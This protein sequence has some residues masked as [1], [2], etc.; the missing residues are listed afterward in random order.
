MIS[1]SEMSIQIENARQSGY[2]PIYKRAAQQFGFTV[3]TLLA[4]DSRESCLGLCLD[5][6]FKGDNGNAWGLS[7]ID[8]RFHPSF[9]S[10]HDPTDHEAVVLYGASLLRSDTNA[11]GMLRG[12]LV[13][14]NAGRDAVIDAQAQGLNLDVYTT[15]GDYSADVLTRRTQIERLYPEFQPDVFTAG[16][17]WIAGVFLGGGLLYLTVDTLRK[18]AS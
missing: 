10:L 4:K 3:S 2:L 13:A 18:R 5:A 15:G 16:P 6:S 7:Q 8:R 9:T 14:Y 17:G 11:L 12:G 1:D